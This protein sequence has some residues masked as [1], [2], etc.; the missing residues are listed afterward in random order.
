M[1]AP[2]ATFLPLIVSNCG[3]SQAPRLPSL[4]NDQRLTFGSGVVCP[5]GV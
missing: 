5:S 4:T 1:R 3:C 2:V